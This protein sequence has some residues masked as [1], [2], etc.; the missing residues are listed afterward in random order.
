[1]ES[2]IQTLEV[3]LK[4]RGRSEKTIRTYSMHLQHFF[5]FVRKE[6][7]QVTEYDI[8]NYL[9]YLV[10]TK[11]CKNS[12]INLILSVLKFY[13]SELL[14]RH[15]ISVKTVKVGRV[16]PK[17]LTKEEVLR[18]FESAGSERAKLILALLYGTGMRVSELCNLKVNDI[19]W[20]EGYG[21]IRGG[22]GKKDRLFILPKK[23]KKKLY[24]YVKKHKK[25]YVFP[26]RKGKLTERA[27][28]RLVQ[29][30]AKRAGLEKRVTPHT[31]RHSFATHLLDDGVDIR[32]IQE[33][34]GHANL[35]TTQIYTYISTTALKSIRSPIDKIL[36]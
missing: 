13:F 35:S 21:W 36:R 3:E 27:V 24:K 11:K 2:P 8:K 9:K 32:K 22:K 34:L 14:K 26:G 28:Q 29:R 15:I 5:D 20:S 1:M 23:I 16:L 17:V 12:T 33:L 10:Y 19:E 18:L 30:T 4:L 31:L 25:E 7:D 6:P